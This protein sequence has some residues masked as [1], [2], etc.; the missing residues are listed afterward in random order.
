[1][2]YFSHQH[3]KEQNRTLS[4]STKTFGLDPISSLLSSVKN[5]TLW[6]IRREVEKEWFKHV[7]NSAFVK[8]IKK[9]E[10]VLLLLNR[11]LCFIKINVIARIKEKPLEQAGSKE[12]IHALQPQS[13]TEWKEVGRESLWTRYKFFIFRQ[14]SDHKE[15]WRNLWDSDWVFTERMS[16]QSRFDFTYSPS[17]LPTGQDNRRKIV[18]LLKLVKKEIGLAC[19]Y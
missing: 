13:K 14:D 15:I 1:M 19:M 4:R 17:A 8:K 11:S 18:N 16:L 9:Y 3:Q 5:R 10:I 12:T 7:T 6:R 2:K